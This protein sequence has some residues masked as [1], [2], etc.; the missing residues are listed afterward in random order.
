MY[1]L[2][3]ALRRKEQRLNANAH[4]RNTRSKKPN[5]D[6]HNFKVTRP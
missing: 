2:S 1:K 5:V 3:Q 4:I 6:A